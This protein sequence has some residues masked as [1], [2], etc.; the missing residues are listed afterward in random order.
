MTVSEAVNKYKSERNNR[1][2]TQIFFCPD[3][4]QRPRIGKEYTI[5]QGA[6][7]K[8]PEILSDLVVVDHY[9]DDGVLC[10]YYEATPELTSVVEHAISY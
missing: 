10:I 4:V 6:Q 7:S 9:I 3:A 1:K 5:M 8:V 2:F